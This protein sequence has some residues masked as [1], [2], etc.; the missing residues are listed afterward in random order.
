MIA[1]LVSGG[2]SGVD[3]AALDAAL[4]LGLPCGGWCP[5]GRKAEDGPIA[6]RYPLT[7]TPSAQYSQRTRWNIR[8]SDGTLILSWGELTGGTL[9]TADECRKAGKPHLVLDLADEEHLLEAIATARTW[10]AANVASGVLNVAGPRESSHPGIYDAAKEFL[11]AVLDP[12]PASGE[13][14][15]TPLSPEPGAPEQAPK[16][17]APSPSA[18]A[19]APPRH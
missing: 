18:K 4:E 8:D 6:D 19:T 15:G 14:P 2:Q 7:E 12:R 16:A 10:G 5:K 11:R 3:R 13:A 9:L 17:A 1:R